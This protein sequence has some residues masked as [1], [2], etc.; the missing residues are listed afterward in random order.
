M[1]R[2]S[3]IL[4]ICFS[5]S[6]LLF[7]EEPKKI[8]VQLLWKHQFEFAGF[9]MAKEK[10]FYK[11]VGL[12]VSFKEYEFG[13]DISKDVSEQKSDFGVGSSSLILDKI[14]GLDVYL[15]M[16][17][18]QT[19]PL[20]LMTKKDS[21]I[22]SVSDLKNKKIMLTQNQISMASLNAMFKVNNLKNIDYITQE[23]SFK[24][25]DLIDGKTDA[26][27]VYSSNEPFHLIDKNI[28]Y[29]IFDPID[30]G[31]SFYE[32]ILYTSK[33][34]YNA[35]PDIVRKFYE[36]TKKG[37]DYAYSNINETAK[38]IQKNYNTQHKSYAHLVYEGNELKK[39]AHFESNEYCKFKPEV[40]GQIIQTYNLLDISKATVNINDFIYPDAIDLS[41]LKHT[42][43]I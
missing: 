30:Y 25:E 36:A 12:D 35:N 6:S 37:W 1:L 2:K 14:N 21:D 9:Y 39:M 11:D 28:K 19:S 33:K 15:L 22:K 16:P 20:V 23:H 40:I 32:D 24:I 29:T 18:L 3:I 10:G 27:S 4:L 26:M 43:K 41:T 5:L 8:S 34:F 17:I 7:A 42:Q 38:V 13:T 31:F